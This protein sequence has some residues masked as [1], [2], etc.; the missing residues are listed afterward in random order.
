M[1]WSGCLTAPGALG[2]PIDGAEDL[3]ASPERPETI[4]GFRP[5]DSGVDQG[6]QW[7]IDVRLCTPSSA[8]AVAESSTGRRM[9]TSSSFQALLERR[10]V[11]RSFQLSRISSISAMSVRVFPTARAAASA[12]AFTIGVTS[13][14]R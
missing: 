1:L 13:P 5:E 3:F 2:E 9:S 8:A 7:R 6:R 10:T 4:F 12:K 11:S 14:V